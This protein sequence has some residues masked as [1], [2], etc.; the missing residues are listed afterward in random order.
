MATF[1]MRSLM[2]HFGDDGT[3]K[4][5]STVCKNKNENKIKSE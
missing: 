1:P 2:V 4:G 3:D 5:D